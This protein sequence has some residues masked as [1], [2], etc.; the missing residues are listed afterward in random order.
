VA[1]RLARWRR[2]WAVLEKVRRLRLLAR[3]WVKA[4]LQQA[5][6]QRE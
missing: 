5:L 6:P 1:R 2:C 3:H 4:R